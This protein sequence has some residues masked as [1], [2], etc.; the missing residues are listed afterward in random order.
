MDAG[1]I[2]ISAAATI[3]ELSADDQR[4]S[5]SRGKKALSRD[6]HDHYP[7]PPSVVEALL[8]KERF[9]ETVWEPACGTGAMSEVLKK[10]GYDVRSSDL[11]DRG[12]GVSVR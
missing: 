11:I 4:H 9:G 5:V 2:A 10:A 3:A 7:T 1:K 12:Y 8:Q 6:P